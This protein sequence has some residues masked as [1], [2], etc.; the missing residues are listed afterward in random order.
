MASLI[1]WLAYSGATNS[2]GTAVASGTAY[3]Y[4]PGTTNTKVAVYSD[5]DGLTALTQPVTLDASGRAEVYAKVACRVVVLDSTGASVRLEDRANTI[6]AAQVEVEQAGY[7][8]TDL[9]TGSQVDGGR[10]D[11]STQLANAY[12]SFGPNFRYSESS[13]ATERNYSTAVGLW[14]T[15]QDFGAA[16]DDATDDTTAFQNAINRAMASNKGLFIPPGTYRT[17]TGLTVTGATGTGLVIQGANRATCIIKSY[18]A[19]ADCLAIDLSSAIESFIVLANFQITNSSTSSGAAVKL[20]NGDGVRIERVTVGLHREGF[21]CTAVSYT[22]LTD[23]V[24]ASCDSNAAAKGYRLGA[25]ATALHCRAVNSTMVTGFALEG[26]NGNL[27]YCKSLAATTKGFDISAASCS[28]MNCHAAGATVGFFLTGVANCSLIANTGSGN[29]ADLSTN[30]SSTNLADVG[31]IFSTRSQS[32]AVGA[33]WFGTRG[34]VLKRN[35]TASA[36]NGVTWTPDPKLGELQILVNTNTSGGAI[37]VAAT[38][39][40]GLVDGQLMLMVVENQQNTLANT[41]TLNAQYV[42]YETLLTST[43]NIPGSGANQYIAYFTWNASASKW[44]MT[45]ALKYTTTVAAYNW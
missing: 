14:V 42:N 9:T 27:S 22:L 30:A 17:T 39:T 31:N 26:A 3:F 32:E 11:L 1:S 16:G 38:A 35:R 40:T 45:M 8:G 37:T 13:T 29:T 2:S 19:S 4:Q 28:L 33:N 44:V 18:H 24:V 23:C 41:I 20:T 21:N 25:H 12:A 36:T 15:P 34:R 5:A 6:A 43:L 7:T 10:T